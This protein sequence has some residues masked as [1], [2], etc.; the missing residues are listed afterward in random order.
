[1]RSS[2]PPPLRWL[3]VPLVVFGLGAAAALVGGVYLAKSEIERIKAKEYAS[4]SAIGSLKASQLEQ[5]R[6]DFAL[7]A[8]RLSREKFLREAIE[9]NDSA[10]MQERLQ[11]Y[12]GPKAGSVAEILLFSPQ[13][14]PLLRVSDSPQ[15]TDA[16]AET[17]ATLA[18]AISEA[19][20]TQDAV[21]SEMYRTPDGTIHLDAVAAVRDAGGRPL[22]V[23]VLR[24]NVDGYL[25]PLL[26]R[27][28]TESKTAQT[29]LARL[30]GD[31]VIYLNN[32]RQRPETAM[33]TR[34]PISETNQPVVQ[35]V[36]GK[37]GIIEGQDEQGV[38]VLAD[39]RQIPR[40]SWSILATLERQEM[41]ADIPRR[42]ALIASIVVLLILL[43]ALSV[44]VFYD[45]KRAQ[46]ARSL[47]EARERQREAE[48]I[49]QKLFDH[50]LNGFAAHE[51]I[52]DE[53]GRPKDYRFVSVNPAYERITG[54]RADALLGRTVMEVLPRTESYWLE[55][56]GQVLRTGRPV[57]FENYSTDL[58]QHFE[59]SAFQI[60][61]NQFGAIIANVT[62]RKIAENKIR[63]SEE[64]F[65]S[66]IEN[67]PDAVFVT[68]PDGFFLDVNPSAE[69]ISGYTRNE[70]I[71]KHV[72]DLTDP[73]DRARG[74]KHFETLL[75]TGGAIDD[76]RHVT[77]DGDVRTWNI[78]AVRLDDRRYLSFAADV[79]DLRRSEER[80]HLNAQRSEAFLQLPTAIERMSEQDF[81]RFGLELAGNLT[82]S[83][84]ALIHFVGEEAE[85]ASLVACSSRTIA[86][87]G[88]DESAYPANLATVRSEARRNRAAATA[89]ETSVPPTAGT[90][91]HFFAV[92][93]IEE[94]RVVML[95]SL[96]KETSRHTDWDVETVQLIS[97]DLWHLVQRRRGL[98]AL[99]ASGE[100]FRN[101]IET[102]Q[103]PFALYSTDGKVTYL[104]SAFTQTFGY[105]T[106]DVPTIE[107]WWPKAYPDP[108][109]RERIERAWQERVED[110]VNNRV[111]FKPLEATIQCKDGK[112]CTIIA[113]ASPLGGA[114]EGE[115]IV[116]FFDI[117]A[118]KA[119][120]KRIFRLSQ[121]YLALSECSEAIVKCK[122]PL[123]LFRAVCRVVVEH[124]GLKMA[125]VGEI[126]EADKSVNYRATFGEGTEY[127][128]EAGISTDADQV[129]GR[130][131][132][133]TAARENRP[134]WCQDFA[135]DPSVAAWRER[136]ARYGWGSLA[137]VPLRRACLPVAILTIYSETAN[138]FD[139]EVRTLIME[140]ADNISFALDNFAR[141]AAR[142]RAET[143][144]Q[145]SR[146]MLAKVINSSPQ[147]VFWKD[148][149][150]VYL[151]CNEVFARSVALRSPEEIVGKTDFDL[152]FPRLD[153]EAYRTADAE[154]MKTNQPMIHKLDIQRRDDGKMTWID[155]CK[156]ALVDSE[157]MVYGV[158][159]I[160]EDITDRKAAED[161]LGKLRIA[162]EQSANIVLITDEEGTIVYV[163]PAFERSTGYTREE[164]LGRNPRLLKSGMHPAEFYREIWATIKSGRSWQGQLQNKRKDGSLYWESAVISPVIGDQG[165][166]LYFI[167]VKED[168]SERKSLESSL[169]QAL[170]RA[171]TA[172]RAKSEF[173]A[174]MSHELRTP[175]NGVLGFAELLSE[176]PLNEEQ[177]EFVRTIRSSG[178]HLLHVVNDVL[179]FSS[180]EQSTVRL[181]KNPFV[182][183]DLLESAAMVVRAGTDEKGLEF[184]HE[185][186]DD[187]PHI[188]RGDAR[189][190]RQI[191]INLLGNAVKFTETGS[192][193]L[194]VNLATNDRGEVVEFAVIDTGPGISLEDK[195][196][197]F[198]P[199]TQG[200]STLS[201]RFRGTGLGLAI[202][203]RLAQAMGGDITIES[204]PGDGSTFALRLPCDAVQPVILEDDEPEPMVPE[205]PSTPGGSPRAVLV[206][207]DDRVSSILAG[208]MTS[209]LGYNVEIVRDG[210]QALETFQPGKYCAI[211]MDLQ[212]PGLDGIE[213]TL[214]IRATE[215][216]TNAAP[217]PI[218]ALTANVMPGNRERCLAAGMNDFLSKPLA[219]NDLAE[220]L[221]RLAGLA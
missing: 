181:E 97:N 41:F 168:I 123:E 158:L 214:R 119:A 99:Q 60:A 46:I 160:V 141:E 43:S 175:L 105:T 191:L 11:E 12:L 132:T 151:G 7:G 182:L 3:I 112:A 194:R 59:V 221:G 200:D 211:L 170:S 196:Q 66:Y 136:G 20:K 68:D 189:R 145:I 212:M 167:A 69:R 83:S 38:D 154:V 84:L 162:V 54:L 37:T 127:L 202:S 28:P 30:E 176:T 188:L 203:L 204:T 96:G 106:A 128:A 29:I 147:A 102:S 27:W 63:E 48:E 109:Y 156:V 184:H 4:L 94:G 52:Y 135:N 133:G 113:T 116:N 14:R 19:L 217:V 163:N 146:D 36:L 56:F 215:A 186:A 104:N 85:E 111:P 131:P 138:A 15:D 140:M 121:I 71:G 198:K 21:L 210:R 103:L 87:H 161:E 5:W 150:S 70:L 174:V 64:R 33:R 18:T 75:A 205:A 199:F 193:H 9:K 6:T 183:A 152:P 185:M 118:R 72:S 149:N 159:G 201:R 148:R 80:A 219:K 61:P 78:K 8:L 197:L 58:G 107:A 166:L 90:P 115:I 95:T 143:D 126:N 101:V 142:Q 120:E 62:E 195:A 53:Q 129:G 130:G 125:C 179:D 16:K 180:I 164:A 39:A 82:G 93:V 79:H 92:P 98:A 209:L 74:K 49:Y 178:D 13:G 177:Q 218:I 81:I 50:M 2:P 155:T 114:N 122:E 47:E 134:V 44:K 144:L 139:A 10:Q 32:L 100:R 17:P 216:A 55:A 45:W 220:K 157:G 73:Q 77:K 169:K 173:L 190:I 51:M 1:M 67:A 192:V 25:F 208:K 108:E 206:V 22:A 35:A 88:T 76:V 34:F 172:S 165:E 42:L 171:E 24:E 40:S 213:T 117:T 187:V 124:G 89:S 137:A 110:V 26:Q 65:R 31:E 57:T 207:E 153:C 86:E 91:S 23:L